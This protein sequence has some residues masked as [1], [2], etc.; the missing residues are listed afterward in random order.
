MLNEREVRFSLQKP[1]PKIVGVGIFSEK[2]KQK[3]KSRKKKR[4][5]YFR[6]RSHRARVCNEKIIQLMSGPL[7]IKVCII[8]DSGTYYFYYFYYIIRITNAH[9]DTQCG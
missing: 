7:E 9:G 4:Q 6:R 8:G 2:C 1:L 5:I 3:Q